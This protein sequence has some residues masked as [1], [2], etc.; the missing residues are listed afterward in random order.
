MPSLL[1]F[2]QWFLSYGIIFEGIFFLLLL[3]ASMSAFYVYYLCK[4]Q[5]SK[6]LG[7]GFGLLAL[8]HASHGLY[9]I[10]FIASFLYMY[11]ILYLLGIVTLAHMTFR[12]Q[13]YS[14]LVLLSALVLTPLFIFGLNLT[15]FNSLSAALLLFMVAYYYSRFITKY[16][17]LG[18]ISKCRVRSV[19]ST[20]ILLFLA[21]SLYAIAFSSPAI[22]ITG[23]FLELFAYFI[24]LTNILLVWRRKKH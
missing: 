10:L 17:Q 3:F 23:H 5:Q 18:A 19:F 11:M 1:S 4:S 12:I 8:A 21:R 9:G 13:N 6:F 20:F 16:K 14:V 2:P 22:Y 7:I 24:I 15:V